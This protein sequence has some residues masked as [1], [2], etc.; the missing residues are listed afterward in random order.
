MPSASNALDAGADFAELGRL[1]QHLHREALAHQCQRRGNAA[2][3]AAGDQDG[4][5]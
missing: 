3:A 4:K 1:L 5:S 2:N